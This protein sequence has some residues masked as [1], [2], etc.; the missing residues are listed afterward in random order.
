MAQDVD[1]RRQELL[2][3]IRTHQA[4]INTYVRKSQSRRDLVANVSIISS[5][6]AAALVVGPTVGGATFAE[7]VQ[8]GLGFD[9]SSSVWRLLCFASL[10][11]NLVAAI[12]ANLNKSNDPTE[13]INIA[14]ACNAALEGLRAKVE[15]GN[16]SVNTAVGEYGQIVVKA[17]FV[18]GNLADVDSQDGASAPPP[19]RYRS[20]E[21]VMPG[22]A[23]V[24]GSIIVVMT[25]IGLLLGQGEGAAADS[26]RLVLSSSQVKVGDT[27]SITA[28]GFSPGEDVRFS[29]AGPTSGTIGVFRANTDGS[30]THGGILEKDPPGAYAITAIGLTSG[31]I[32]SSQLVVQPGN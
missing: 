17:L 5:A 15:F 8:K 32:V 2:R 22:M 19:S 6:I 13:R 30:T 14:E 21:V 31:R 10:I 16:M 25:V 1:V 7:T 29:W 12:S 9:K 18:P 27:Y 4:S 23:I 26:P 11:V 3:R 20:A 24:F 28:S